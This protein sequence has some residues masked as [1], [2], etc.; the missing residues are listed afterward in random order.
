MDIAAVTVLISDGPNGNTCL[1][2]IPLI[3]PA[4][5]VI[6]GRIPLGLLGEKS[7]IPAGM[8]AV[9]LNIGLIHHIDTQLRSDLIE[10]RMIGIVGAPNGIHVVRL[11]QPQLFFNSFYC[12][13]AAVFWVVLVAV[14]TL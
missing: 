4:D 5:T 13:G 10:S 11:D 1:I 14:N 6:I 2:F 12:N 3:H 7:H 9:G 8:G